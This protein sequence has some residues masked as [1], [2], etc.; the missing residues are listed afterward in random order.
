MNDEGPALGRASGDARDVE[1]ND[2]PRE[3]RRGDVLT[4]LQRR[5]WSPLTV[6]GILVR[7]AV[8]AQAHDLAMAIGKVMRRDGTFRDLRGPDDGLCVEVGSS[9]RH[10]VLLLLELSPWSW[11]AYVR[12]WEAAR[13]A[14]RCSDVGRGSVRLLMEP[15]DVCPVPG[16]GKP[17]PTATDERD[18]DVAPSND[19]R[20]SEQ[21]SVLLAPTGIVLIP[22][23]ASRDEEG[24]EGPRR[25]R[26]GNHGRLTQGGF[27][28]SERRLGI[29]A[30]GADHCR[31][32]GA[33]SAE[34]GYRGHA[35]HCRTFWTGS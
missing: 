7:P 8:T 16:C 10:K 19:E 31:E 15:A 23:D 12:R 11:R 27:S 25:S 4:V 13:I 24:D 33:T 14:H 9:H 20:G 6:D 35:M 26:F 1:G 29:A 22:G 32:C 3:G 17:L 30:A 34:S 2:T 5:R 21:Q 18:S 28:K